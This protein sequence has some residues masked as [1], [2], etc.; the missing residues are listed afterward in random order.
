[1]LENQHSRYGAITRMLPAT[2]GKVFFVIHADNA[3][4][5]HLLEEFPVD[6]D[7]VPRVYQTTSGAA[8]DNLAIQAGLDA[9]VAGRDDYVIILPSNGNDYDLGALLTM[10]K[11]NVHLI[12]LEAINADPIRIG[13]SRGVV[14]EQ[15]AS[16]DVAYITGQNCE[17]AGFYIKNKANYSA[18]QAGA[19]AHTMYIHHNL[20]FIQLNWRRPL[21]I[22]RLV[23]FALF[24]W[25]I[26]LSYNT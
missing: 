3:S 11:N 17:F 8:T 14:L 5:N 10:S 18:V 20:L 2:L 19:T 15:T 22:Y 16:V 23:F 6:R 26:F 13:A 7:G 24:F 4:D 12:S 21:I 9:C 25:I 1:M